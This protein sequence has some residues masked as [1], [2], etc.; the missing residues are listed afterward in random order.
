MYLPP[1]MYVP[2]QDNIRLADITAM[3]VE[4]FVFALPTREVLKDING[5]DC[6]NV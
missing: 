2:L 4:E 3:Y 6:T 1:E 5:N